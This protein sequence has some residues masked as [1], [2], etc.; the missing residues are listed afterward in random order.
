MLTLVVVWCA[1]LGAQSLACTVPVAS[2]HGTGPADVT[3]DLRAALLRCPVVRVKAGRHVTK[4][5]NMTSNQVLYLELGSVLYG[6]TNFSDYPIIEPLPTFGRSRD[7]RSV[8]SETPM[9]YQPLVFAYKQTNVTVSGQG[10]IDGQG[11]VWWNA[12]FHYGRPGLVEFLMCQKVTVETVTLR[13][14]PFWT[15]HLAISDTIV[16]AASPLKTPRTLETQ[17]ASILTR[18]QTLTSATA[19]LRVVMTALR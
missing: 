12:T 11:S 18:R 2:H 1:I 19:R 14:S 10:V 15:L 16:F 8:P 3:D 13:N 17:T 9:R 7:T 4:P 5:F 6:S